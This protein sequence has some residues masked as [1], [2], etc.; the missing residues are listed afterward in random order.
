[1]LITWKVRRCNI[2]MQKS[3]LGTSLSCLHIEGELHNHGTSKC[4]LFK[5][6]NPR[7]FFVYFFPQFKR[8]IVSISTVK[9]VALGIRTQSPRNVYRRKNPLCY[10]DLFI[11]KLNLQVEGV[12][13]PGNVPLAFSWNWFCFSKRFIQWAIPN[14]G[15]KQLRLISSGIVLT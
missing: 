8:D 4:L 7:F 14:V 1:M 2:V 3:S 13:L 12:I 9:H 5:W 10:G 6:T 15:I 11:K